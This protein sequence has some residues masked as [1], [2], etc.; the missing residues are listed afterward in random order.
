MRRYDR[1]AV[2]IILVAL[3]SHGLMSLNAGIFWDDW[4]LIGSLR[5]SPGNWALTQSGA[6]SAATT[7]C[8]VKPTTAIDAPGGAGSTASVPSGRGNRP[9]AAASRRAASGW[10]KPAAGR[11]GRAGRP[12]G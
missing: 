7:W 12:G 8:A 10:L 5:S 2:A 4:L 1:D 3:V 6:T 11:W 9:R